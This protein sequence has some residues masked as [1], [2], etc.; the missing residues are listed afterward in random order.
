MGKDFIEI[1]GLK[2]YG[3]H[4][5]LEEE[6]KNGQPFLIDAKLFFDVS[7]VGMLDE[8][9]NTI[10]Y[11]KVCE[12]IKAVF[13][14]KKYDLIETAAEA[15]ARAVLI[16]YE[17]VE[18][19]NIIL[20]KPEAPIPMEFMDVSVNIT[21]KWNQVY[22]GVGSNMGDKKK[23]IEEAID[24]LG[25]YDEIKN[26]RSSTLIITKPYG[27]VE[28]D[29][30]LNGAVELKTLFNPYELLEVLH[31]LE[32][33]AQRKREIHWGPRTL[34]LDILF[35]ED[36]V[37]STDELNIPHIDMENRLFVLEPLN[38]LAPDFINPK[39]KIKVRKMLENLRNKNE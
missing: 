38:E 32:K 7:R 17:K 20:H 9:D 29:D 10:D 12:T 3:Y 21:R 6:K 16:N 39:S 18:E 37:M 14:E 15:V 34:D 27:G 13:L 2:I 30:F 4:G 8:L 11:S 19:V 33:N 36:I 5:V 24:S 22:L 25:K 23:Y 28:Q 1:K 26:V 31:D 35:Y